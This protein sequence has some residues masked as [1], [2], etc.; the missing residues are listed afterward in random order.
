MQFKQLT[1][2]VTSLRGPSNDPL[3]QPAYPP[4]LPEPNASPL[5][6]QSYMEYWQLDA[7][8]VQ[9]LTAKLGSGPAAHIPSATEIA[10][11][12][13][14]AQQIYQMLSERYSGSDYA[15]GLVQKIKLWDFCYTRS[16]GPG[17]EK[18]IN[19]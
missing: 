13:R 18:Y 14:T 12:R 16:L 8:V 5:D 11:E 9:V 2:W 3:L 7:L 17:L 4:P 1:D 19:M 15:D 10:R 6:W